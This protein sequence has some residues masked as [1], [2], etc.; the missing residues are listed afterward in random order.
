MGN[1]E[2][3]LDN[4]EWR[5][6]V[7]HFGG[8]SVDTSAIVNAIIQ[9]PSSFGLQPYKVIVVKNKE[10][11]EKLVN[12]SFGQAQVKECDTLFVF[13]AR[14]DVKARVE[15]YILANNAEAMREMMIGF[16]NNLKD[17][18]AWTSKQAY[19]A[20][21]FALAAATEK[22][23]ASCPMEGFLP[24]EVAKILDLNE[25]LVPCVYLA[26]GEQVDN[27]ENMPRFRFPESD[28]LVEKN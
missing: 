6:A 24:N 5:R 15:E 2:S 4:I 27:E 22:K 11:K 18:V 25:N 16:V 17:P 28:I 12:A 1:T 21:G 10:L 9:A 26:V 13:C 23:I 19:I 14:K 7:K 20:L 8:G 3:F